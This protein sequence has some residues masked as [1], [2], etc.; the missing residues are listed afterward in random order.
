MAGE[1]IREFAR[2][3]PLYALIVLAWTAAILVHSTPAKAEPPQHAG[4]STQRAGSAN[5][6]RG[7]QRVQQAGGGILGSVEMLGS[8]S[9]AQSSHS[10]RQ[11][12]IDRLPLDRLTNQA[13][14]RILSIVNS[15]TLYR[16][17]PTQAIRCDRDMFLVL[18]RNPEILVGL[19]DLMGVTKVK[20]RRTAPF[21][22]EAQDG[23]GT[24]C[25]ID[26]DYGDSHTHI[27]VADGSYDGKLV[28]KPIQ[29]QAVFVMHSTYAEAA[30][31][32]TTVTGTLDCFIQFKSL[33]A[34]LLAR[35][36]SGLI[37]R[38]A[39]HNYLE[40]AHF[41]AQVSQAAERNPAALIEVAQRIPQ[42]SPPTRKTFVDVI[43]TVARRYQANPL[44]AARATAQWQPASVIRAER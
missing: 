12:V 3:G 10:R 7:S 26:L 40:T 18:T 11:Q 15:P 34:D 38:S 22:L 8:V 25:R 13:Q 37:G 9:A 27:F 23:T 6:A 28:A 42:V 32:G 41:I 16:R 1:S 4:S 24:Q 29:G 35:T 36:L 31:G 21:Q 43:A 19:W 30:D 2:R 14:Q 20:T 44:T 39:D 17:L 5:A 33:G